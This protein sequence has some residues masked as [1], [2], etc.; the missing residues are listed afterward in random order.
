MAQVTIIGLHPLDYTDEQI[1]QRTTHH[2][3]LVALNPDKETRE[4]ADFVTRQSL[5]STVLVE[6]LIRGRDRTMYMGD[7]G[8]SSGDF[9]G[10]NDPVAY[11][12]AF[13]SLDGSQRV[14]DYLDQV[15]GDDVRVAFYLHNYQ[16]GLPILT[17][18][19][20][21]QP[22]LMTAMPDRLKRLAPYKLPELE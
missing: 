18:Y 6:M 1:D 7:F 10:P 16:P 21:V 8:Q 13:L 5:R 12:E 4:F 20:P 19:G 3:G 11:E 15:R 22:P 9:I 17:S 14:A 2:F